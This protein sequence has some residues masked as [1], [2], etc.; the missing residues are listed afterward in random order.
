MI[1]FFAASF[2]F[3]NPE[4]AAATP[5]LELLKGGE[6]TGKCRRNTSE[7]G[8]AIQTTGTPRLQSSYTTANGD[9]VW[10]VMSYG[11][12]KC[13]TPK[14]GDR[15]TFKCEIAKG[16]EYADC[17]QTQYEASADGRTWETKPQVDHAGKTL[18][19][20][21]RVKVRSVKGSKVR[22][23]TIGETEEPE[24]ELLART[25]IRE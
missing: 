23:T 18:E 11:D 12:P 5:R 15:H 9:L 8:Q 21:M 13:E 25:N 3:W 7:A 16:A 2:A 20:V 1:G 19:A 22:I 24:S 17:K 6:W 10:K 14:S 4:S